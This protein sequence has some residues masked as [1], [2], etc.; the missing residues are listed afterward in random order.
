MTGLPLAQHQGPDGETP[1]LADEQQEQGPHCGGFVESER[2]GYDVP[3][4]GDPAEEGYPHSVFVYKPF[5]LVKGLPLDL[6]RLLKPL[7]LRQAPQPVG[8]HASE[9]VPECAD[10]Q[11]LH[12]L[13]GGIQYSYIECIRAERDDRCSKEAPYEK[14]QQAKLFEAEHTLLVVCSENLEVALGMSAGGA[15]HRRGLT[16]DDVTAVAALPDLHA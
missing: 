4:D 2:E 6:E 3:H 8:C 7:P 13:G 15:D 14:P 5:L 10:H 1:E 16:D 9:P 11:A 12:R